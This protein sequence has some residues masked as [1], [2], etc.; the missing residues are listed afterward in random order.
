M[1][2][3]CNKTCQHANELLAKKRH[4]WPLIEAAA[5]ADDGGDQDA[6]DTYMKVARAAEQQGWPRHEA[7]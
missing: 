3:K 6:A 2:H 4:T 1:G 7:R 5:A